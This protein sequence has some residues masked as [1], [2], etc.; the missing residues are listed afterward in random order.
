MSFSSGLSGKAIIVPVFILVLFGLT[1]LSSAGIVDSQNR[2]S[3]SYYYFVHQLLYGFLPGVLLFW[4]CFKIKYQLWK[5]L[6]VP[7]LLLSLGFLLAVFLPGIGIEARGAMRWIKIGFLSFQ[8]SEIL[9]LTLIIYF[10]AWFSGRSEKVKSWSYSMVP[11]LVILGFVGVLLVKQPDVGTLSIVVMIAIAMYFLAGAD[12]KHFAGLMVLMAVVF[13]LLIQFAPYRL[14]RL[15]A[16]VNPSADPQGIAYHVNQAK[17]GIA[18]GGIFGVGFGQ[19][20]QK[21][22][23]LPEPVGDSIFAIV[24]EELGLVG[25]AFL[26]G[27]ILWLSLV[28]IKISRQTHDRFAQLFLLGLT[29]WIAGQAFINIAAISGLIPLTGIPLP[30]VS[31]GGTSLAVM[32]GALGIASNIAGSKLSRSSRG[33]FAD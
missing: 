21:I 32:L 11:F 25:G 15:L 24:A 8:P 7:L 28:L 30:F 33:A 22:N 23:F 12:I 26:L 19:S 31:Y 6:S 13:F 9:K 29:V 18:R 27:V 16:F 10:A 14:N 1:M 2:F 3:S 20:Q 5:K 4:I 17:L